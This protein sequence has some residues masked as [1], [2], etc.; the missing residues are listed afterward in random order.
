MEELVLQAALRRDF[1]V[2]CTE[3]QMQKR[4]S[5]LVVVPNVGYLPSPSDGTG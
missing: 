4:M 1:G 3:W 5:A 2:R